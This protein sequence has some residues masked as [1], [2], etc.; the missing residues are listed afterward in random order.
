MR[1]METLGVAV[2]M[3]SMFAAC[4]YTEGECFPRDQLYETVGAG[5]GV[6]VPG[7][8]GGYGDVPKEPQDSSGDAPRQT[9]ECNAT[10]GD[11]SSDPE[12]WMQSQLED[13]TPLGGVQCVGVDDC[14]TKCADLAKFCAH[15]DAHPYKAGLIG[16]LFDCVDS[17]PKATSGGSYTCLYR[18]SN[19]DACI[20]AY[21]SKFGPIKIPAPPPLCVYK[22]Q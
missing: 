3:V 20:I 10:E 19:G 6:I 22:S 16:D 14:F 4:N 12:K 2:G 18:Y 1:A 21:A 11:A 13:E 7:G 9:L 5:G 15:R 17:F 8:V